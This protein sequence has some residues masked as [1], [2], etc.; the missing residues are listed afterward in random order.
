MNMKDIRAEKRTPFRRDGDLYAHVDN[1]WAPADA[2]L[3]GMSP[4]A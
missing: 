2:A 1:F 4:H 3:F